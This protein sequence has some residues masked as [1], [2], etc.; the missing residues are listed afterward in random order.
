[1]ETG[2]ILFIIL[3]STIGIITSIGL[4]EVI[5]SIISPKHT[6]LCNNV[7][8]SIK[9]CITLILLNILTLSPL[10]A[11]SYASYPNSCVELKQEPVLVS[12]KYILVIDDDII[13]VKNFDPT[14]QE[15][16]IKH[17]PKQTNYFLTYKSVNEVKVVN[18]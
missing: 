13:E 8:E 4:H 3:V 12:G 11:W 6:L 15:V 17:K 7:K 16:V 10:I 9:F 2:D 18:K 1:M 5:V 14:T